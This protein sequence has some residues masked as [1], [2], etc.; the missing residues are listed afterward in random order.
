MPG[1]VAPDFDPTGAEP[2]PP[3]DAAAPG[4]PPVAILPA[5]TVLLVRDSDAGELQVCL[6][7]RNL[8]STFVG[9]V[10]VFPGGAVEP[11]DGHPALLAL[12]DGRTDAQASAALGIAS[13][14][15]AFWVAAIREAFEEAGLLPA[16]WAHSGAPLHFSDD[17]LAARFAAHRGAVDREERS[18]GDVLHEEGLRL[19]VGAMHYLSHWVTPPGRSRRYDTRFFLA[20]APAGQR[21]AHDGRE[22]IEGAWVRPADAIARQEAGELVMRPPTVWSLHQLAQS[23][24]AAEA[25]AASEALTAVPSFGATDPRG[26]A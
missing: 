8:Q 23:A 11:A 10:S 15:L 22:A 5:A 3:P 20:Q 25:L 16:T 6:L 17:A 18:L 26:A 12:C 4:T 21:L 9:G 19:D 7:R 14:G 13:G 24:T 1:A 2:V